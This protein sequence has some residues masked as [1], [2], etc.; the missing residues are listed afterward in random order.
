MPAS[1]LDS[2]ARTGLAGYDT[3]TLAQ[4]A[5]GEKAF[6]PNAARGNRAAQSAYTMGR[7]TAHLI[8]SEGQPAIQGELFLINADHTT[9]ADQLFAV[10]TGSLKISVPTGH[11]TAVFVDT[12]DGA[13]RITAAPE[14]TVKDGTSITLDTR[15]STHRIPVPT[16]PDPATLTSS[17]F[18]LYRSD[19]TPSG[20]AAGPLLEIQRTGDAPTGI[21]L[22]DTAPVR[23]GRFEAVTTFDFASPADADRPYAYHVARS[24]DRLPSSYPTTV[25]QS[26]LTTVR[27]TYSAPDGP[28]GTGV[29][30][31]NATPVWAATAGAQTA[32]GIEYLSTGIT[33]T[34]YFDSAADINWRTQLLDEQ[35]QN[36]LSGP[37][38]SYRPG[39]HLVETW[40]A[41]TPHPSAQLDHGTAAVY[42]G[43]CASK[44]TMVFA[45]AADGDSTP[46][47]IGTGS[48]ESNTVTLTR[49]G[50]ML[51]TGTGGLF[52]ASVSVP[53]GRAH[54]GLRELTTR[55]AAGLPSGT[56]TTWT[57]TAEPGHGKALP[58]R[59]HCAGPVSSCTALP[60]LYVS[61]STDAD[62][63]NQLT[64]GRHT[65]DLTVTRQQYATAPPV[66][67]A[68]LQASYDDGT[69][70]H[71]LRVTG[72]QGDYHAAY[73]VPASSAGGAV[74]LRLS[75]WDSQG[76]R[77]DQTLPDAYRVR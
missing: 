10:T 14:V 16:T 40:G 46:G 8:N 62:I 36:V 71:N 39:H 12:S 31:T 41:G 57:F 75:A 4:R 53:A 74:S 17:E 52:E 58:D 67:G 1:A 60:M 47:T 29:L 77:V 48:S 55:D 35:T 76:N 9:Y 28:D 54:W 23:V 20:D 59:V 5:C 44:D 27:R 7:V 11:Y 22:N 49:D 6:T 45:I 33:R 25:K 18:S 30:I 50:E 51:A 15:T 56:D 69:T 73:T 13:M 66:S 61:T 70:W 21:T 2:A 72:R 24:Y 3:T 63:H 38:T 32:T 19:G 68:K 43:A 42:C 34:E 26:D 37:D 64:T 65:V